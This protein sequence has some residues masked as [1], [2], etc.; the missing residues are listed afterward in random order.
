MRNESTSKIDKILAIARNLPWFDFND[1]A[2][3]ETDKVYLKVLLGRYEKA[4]KIVRLKK[5]CY[6]TRDYL[7]LLKDGGKMSAYLESLGS[8]LYP[9]SYLSLEYVLYQHNILTEI[10]VNFTLVT[11]NKTS[12]LSNRLGTY[13]YRKIKNELFGGFEV[14]QAGKFF[15]YRATKAKALFDYLYLR[16]NSLKGRDSLEELRLNKKLF[17]GSDLSRLEKYIWAEGSKR[18]KKIYNYFK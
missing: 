14:E 12:V 5:G 6:V 8:V 4:G 2:T 10:P 1:L 17:T 15:V 16:K 3:I 13:S 9:E 18:M 11:K 7:D